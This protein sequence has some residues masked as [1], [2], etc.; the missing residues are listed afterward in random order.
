MLYA[1]EAFLSFLLLE[2]LTK[3][4][5]GRGGEGIVRAVDRANISI[6]RGEFVTFLGPSGCGKTT[7]LRLIAGFEFPTQGQIILDGQTI[8]ELPPNQREMAMVFQSYAIF[9]PSE[10]L[11]EYCLWSKNPGA[12]FPKY[13]GKGALGVGIDRTDRP[14]EPGAQCAFRRPAAAGGPGPGPGDGAQSA[15]DG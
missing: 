6:T 7:T 5:T 4:F 8:N 10:R 13:P 12:I 14:G 2:N 3:D 15:A 9:S 11:R 1:Q